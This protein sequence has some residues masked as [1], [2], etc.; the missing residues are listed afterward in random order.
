MRTEI[1]EETHAEL[2]K[3]IPVKKNVVVGLRTNSREASR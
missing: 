3:Y 1:D 2:E